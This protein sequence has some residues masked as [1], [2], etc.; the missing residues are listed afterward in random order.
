VPDNLELVGVNGNIIS[1]PAMTV[2]HG[3]SPR[4]G[5][6]ILPFY[7]ALLIKPFCF[8]AV[9]FIQDLIYFRDFVVFEP[10]PPRLWRSC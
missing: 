4:P 2:V 3:Q 1:S 6:C 5:V 8:S 9:A 10:D 7:L